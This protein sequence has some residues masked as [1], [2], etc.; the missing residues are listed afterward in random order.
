MDLNTLSES[1]LTQG[2][3]IILAI[4]SL[5]GTIITSW[6][7]YREK[8]RSKTS[9]AEKAAKEEAAREKKEATEA[10]KALED[11][12]RQQEIDELRRELKDLEQKLE[13]ANAS[14]KSSVTRGDR[15]HLKVIGRIQD[16]EESITKITQVLAKNARTYSG[17]MRM[18]EQT[19][20]KLRQLIQLEH[21]N[22]E[23]TRS[24]AD[25]LAELATTIEKM[26]RNDGNPEHAAHLAELVDVS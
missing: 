25:I 15:Q 24:V 19:T 18:N 4:V 22:L 6:F 26:V 3:A 23:L 7:S 10:R 5:M 17:L 13:Q 8:T 20:E 11:A 14:S 9:E 1:I 12:H 2:T 16:N 21:N